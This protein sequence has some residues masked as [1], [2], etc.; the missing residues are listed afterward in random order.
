[1]HYGLTLYEANKGI[2]SNENWYILFYKTA[3][4]YSETWERS[5]NDTSVPVK[6]RNVSISKTVL[7]YLYFVCE[8]TNA[9]AFDIYMNHLIT[10]MLYAMCAS[11]QTNHWDTKA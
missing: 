1:M 5:T 11:C 2:E 8:I 9:M 6:Q 10:W 4:L 3:L 7:E